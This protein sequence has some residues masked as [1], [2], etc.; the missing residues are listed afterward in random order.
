MK[1]NETN[2]GVISLKWNNRIVC[3]KGVY[4]RFYRTSGFET[5]DMF[6]RNRAYF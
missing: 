2:K 4:I 5:Q 3:L 6:K 1:R